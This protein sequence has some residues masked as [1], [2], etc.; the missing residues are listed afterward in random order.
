MTPEQWRAAGYTLFVHP[1]CDFGLGWMLENITL[2][3]DAYQNGI[4][5]PM[6]PPIVL[7]NGNRERII[8]LQWLAG[9]DIQPPPVLFGQQ[10]PLGTIGSGPAYVFFS[11]FKPD[12]HVLFARY[13]RPDPCR[14]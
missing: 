7:L 3:T 8:G 2:W 10:M 6:N 4:V 9:A 12:G 5:D 11:F 14:R 13:D 1:E